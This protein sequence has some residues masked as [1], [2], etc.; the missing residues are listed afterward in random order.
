MRNTMTITRNAV[1]DAPADLVFRAVCTPQAFRRVTRGV[2]RFPVI[3]TRSHAWQE[4]ET[5]VGWTW[6]F[7]VIPFNKH[8]LTVSRIDSDERVLS[9]DEH[10]GVVRAWQHDI[11]VKPVT[12]D[13][14]R[15]TDRVV[16]NAGIMTV[17]VAAYA[18]WFYWV[19]QRRWV[20]LAK[21]LSPR[22]ADA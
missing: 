10:G 6:L 18:W 22:V 16:I 9:S 15:Y 13:S 19:R 4:G 8:H 2:L 7:G 11:I 21:T 5:V 12:T 17:P 20:R 14:C 1:L 3:A